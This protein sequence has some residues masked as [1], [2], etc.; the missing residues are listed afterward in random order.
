MGFKAFFRRLKDDVEGNVLMLAAGALVPLMILVG[1]AVD[2]S[3]AYSAQAKL[4]NACD[5]AVL[6][7]RQSMLGTNLDVGNRAEAQK[8]FDF[9]FPAASLNARNVR[10][11]LGQNPVDQQEIVGTASAEIPTVIM[12]V[13]GYNSVPV[14]V[15]CDAKR[16]QAHNDIVLVLD[17]TG[18]MA[19]A[20]SGGGSAKIDALR[21]GASGLYRALAGAPNSQTRYGIVPY[22][23]TVN[24]ARS[25][26][27]NDILRLQ[28]FIDERCTGSGCSARTKTV[29]VNAENWGSYTGNSGSNINLFRRSGEGCIEERASVGESSS[30]IEIHETITRADVDNRAANA[31]DTALQFGRYAPDSHTTRWKSGSGLVRY[32]LI[33]TTMFAGCPAEAS[34]LTEYADEAGY[35]AAISS[36]TA[37]VRGGTYHDIGMLWGARFISRTG[38]FSSDNPTEIGTVPVNQHIVFMTDGELDTDDRLYSAHGVEPFQQRTQGTGTLDQKHLDRFASACSVAK[39]MGVTVWVIALDVGS[40]DDIEPCATSSDHFFVSDGSDL[41]TVFATIGQGIGNLRLTR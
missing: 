3:L 37:R 24:V 13:F 34:R 29:N 7:G 6:A 28:T 14:A 1:G 17:V 11:N 39:S 41:E 8:F 23:H 25:L 4:Q 15:N 22:S 18:S 16:D 9:N 27:E 36:A 38:F 12:H 31:G 32:G 10:F 19:N 33:G 35:N 5:S 2:M 20:P 30:P 21:T 26:A 40:T